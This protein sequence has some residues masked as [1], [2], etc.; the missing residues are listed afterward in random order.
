MGV[1]PGDPVAPDAPFVVMNGTQSYLGKAWDDRVGCAVLVAAMQRLRGQRHPNQLFWVATVQEEIGLRG[2][3]TSAELVK[4]EI[5]I[6]IEGG[7]VK[8]APGTHPE[9]AQE[10]LGQGP[11]V[12]LYDTSALPN[13]KLVELVKETARSQNIPLQLELIQG[14]GDD[15]A[16]IQKSNGGVPTVNLV[17]PVRFTHS[18]NGIIHRKDFDQMVDLLVA[19]LQRL[20]AA[21]VARVRDFSQ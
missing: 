12:F 15:S 7:V 19:L 14:Y 18:H 5:G 3:K 4:P 20:D 10:I 8:D 2:A 6:A 13:R 21:A 16:E 9:E 11:G 17:V 1:G